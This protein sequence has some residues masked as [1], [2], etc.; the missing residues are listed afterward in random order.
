MK[1][2]FA[3]VLLAALAFEAGAQNWMDALTYAENDYLGTARSVGMGNAMTAV[4]GDLGSLTFNPAGSAVSSYSQF[5]ITPGLS[6]SSV[7]G[8][9]TQLDGKPFGFE[10]AV[11]TRQNRFQLPNVGAVIVYDMHR[12]SGLK[13]VSFGLVGNMTRDYNNYVRATG[14]NDYT[15]LAASLASQADGYPVSTLNGSYYADDIPSWETLVGYQSGIFDPIPESTNYLGLTER[16]LDNG[17]R[18]LADRIGQNYGLKRTGYKYDLLMNLGLDFSDRFFLGANIGISTLSFRNEETRS[19]EALSG[20]NYPSGFNSLRVRSAYVDEA[21]GIYAKIGF[22]ARPFG[23]GLR[24]GAAIQTPTIY[25]FRENYEVRGSSV[26]HGKTMSANSPQDEWFYNLKTPLRFNAGL[27]YTIGKVGLLS[28]DYELCDYRAMRFRPAYESPNADFT[29]RN[30]DMQE[31]L[32]ASHVIRVGG[33]LKP[34]NGMA[35]RVG[36][37]YTTSPEVDVKAGRQSVSFGLGLSSAGSF[38]ADFAVRFQYLPDEFIFPYYYYGWDDEGTY[39]DDSIATPEICAQSSLCNA[40]VTLG[41][42]F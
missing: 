21:S 40:L 22:I 33:E 7:F 25:E 2:I 15:T 26:A 34:T 32:T 38:Y 10:D 13:R 8:Q 14:T 39:I 11:K 37:N 23:G 17:D 16:L 4:G 1:R 9:G 30:R 18:Q 36:Y 19:E 29:G 41:W 28:A 35:I 3:S 27:A 20:A 24:I 42:R 12:S 6:I 5:T 31:F